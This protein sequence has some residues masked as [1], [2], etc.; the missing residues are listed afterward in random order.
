VARKVGVITGRRVIAA[1]WGEAVYAVT[2]IPVITVTESTACGISA[3]RIYVAAAVVDEAFDDVDTGITVRLEAWIA[4]ARKTSR[5]ICAGRIAVTR[6]FVGSA[7]VNVYG[8][9]FSL[10]SHCAHCDTRTGATT[11]RAVV[12]AARTVTR[13]TVNGIGIEFGFTA[14]CPVTVTITK[15]R[16]AG[17]NGSI[18]IKSKLIR[19]GL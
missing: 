9:G 6:G 8:T 12:D 16:N 19:L 1:G 3:R 13:P 14:G 17:G 5:C 18:D 11:R 15:G 10:P 2:R 4:Y 7:L